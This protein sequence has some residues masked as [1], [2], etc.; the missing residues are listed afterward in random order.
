VHGGVGVVAEVVGVE[1]G[2]AGAAA[3]GEGLSRVGRA[4]GVG[5]DGKPWSRVIDASGYGYIRGTDGGDGEQLD[6]W[7]GDTPS[8]QLGFLVTFLT[9][10]GEVDEY[11]ACLAV[12]NYAE[13]RKLIE[14]NY[15]KGFW[16]ERI[17]EV[18]GFFVPDLRKHLK[19]KGILKPSKQKAG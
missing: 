15:P 7:L 6:V 16:D 1:V 13:M 4:V 12:K 14:A 11:K 8:S 19:R 17:G 18:R 10:A 9:P 3:A 5:G 2:G